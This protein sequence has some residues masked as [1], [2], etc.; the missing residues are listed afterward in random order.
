[1]V[2]EIPILFFQEKKSMER[3]VLRLQRDLHEAQS[4]SA[5]QKASA[6]QREIMQ[7]AARV[8]PYL[9]SG[10]I[11]AALHHYAQLIALYQQM[12]EGFLTIKIGLGK[13]MAEMYKSLAIQQEIERLKQQ[14]NPMAQRRFTAPRQQPLSIADRHREQA[15]SLLARKDYDAALPQVNAVLALV[16][17]DPEGR[18][19]LERIQSA[20]R[21]AANG[22]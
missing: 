7:Q 16:P 21:A 1:M 15:R 20:K 18:E 19:M 6:L 2:T 3:E 17:G 11:E 4:A 14:L 10:N 22:I 9:L 5:L 13:E 8:R 12:P